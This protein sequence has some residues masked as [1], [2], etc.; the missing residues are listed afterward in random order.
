MEP[1]GEHWHDLLH[2]DSAAIVPSGGQKHRS[3]E[4]VLDSGTEF[5]AWHRANLGATIERTALLPIEE[6]SDR[7]IASSR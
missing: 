7:R 2:C 4:R 1:V 5:P 3:Q 6:A